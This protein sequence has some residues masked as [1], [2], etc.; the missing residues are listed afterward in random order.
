[1]FKG[2]D[3]S[4]SQGIIDWEKVKATGIEFALIRAGYGSDIESQDDEQAVRNMQECER[5]GIP[6]GVYLY[7]YALKI[8]NAISEAEHALRVVKNFNPQMGIW[9]DMED[10]D[11]YKAK[12]GLNVYNER[13]LITEMCETF[14]DKITEA[15]YKTG[16]Y[17]NK[18]Y[19]DNV[20]ITD[21]IKY[22]L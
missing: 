3:V 1:M 12:K 10:A 7:S 5:L 15:G 11:G 18:N 6:Y 16:I 17:A 9:F 13:E 2:I 8:E 20:I 14:C 19:F 4:Y 21:D 22:R